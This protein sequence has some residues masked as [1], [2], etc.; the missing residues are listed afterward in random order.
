MRIPRIYLPTPLKSGES[1]ELTEHAFQHAI[2]VLRLKQG[3]QLIV[4]DGSGAEFFAT[5]E[6]INKK[7]ASIIITE[8]IHSNSES[9]LSIHL[10]LGISKGERMDFAIQKAVELGVTEITPLFTEFCVVNLDEKR[11]QKRLQHWQGVIISACE[12]SG[13]TVLPILNTTTTLAKWVESIK[14]MCIVFNPEATTTLK[15]ITLNDNFINLI[16]GPEGGLSTKEISELKKK[17]NFH[18]IRFGPRILRTETAA[19]SAITA[20]QMLWGDLLK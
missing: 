7:N 8:A 12:Q 10:G 9:N 6:I 13:R 11:I 20:I 14:N 5:V 19:V 16:I 3:A 17:K 2:K 15:D 18:G 4:F 1:T